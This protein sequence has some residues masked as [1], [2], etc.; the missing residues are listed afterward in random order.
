MIVAMTARPKLLTTF[1]HFKTGI[2]G[3]N[4]VTGLDYVCCIMSYIVLVF[5]FSKLIFGSQ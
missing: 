1:D 2:D 4:P 3:S 5:I